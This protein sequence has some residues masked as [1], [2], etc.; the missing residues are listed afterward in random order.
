MM[1]EAASTRVVNECGI[2][3]SCVRIRRGRARSFVDACGFRAMENK[4]TVM[5][6]SSAGAKRMLMA[7]STVGRRCSRLTCLI[8]S[9]FTTARL[10]LAR[11]SFHA[12]HVVACCSAF[13]LF[14][15]NDATVSSFC[16]GLPSWPAA[17]RR[18]PMSARNSVNFSFVCKTSMPP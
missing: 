8:T 14:P 11:A 4:Y 16:A 7:Q 18:V 6:H 13:L 15:M 1:D 10:V 17:G 2:R 12:M 3:F 9:D 5:L